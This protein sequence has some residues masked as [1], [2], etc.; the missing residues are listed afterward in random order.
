MPTPVTQ[1]TKTAIAYQHYTLDQ[2]K[3]LALAVRTCPTLTQEQKSDL[4][5]LMPSVVL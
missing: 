2:W 5:V 3:N 1:H 4:L